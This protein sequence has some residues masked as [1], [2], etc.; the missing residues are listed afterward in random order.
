M[1]WIANNGSLIVWIVAGLG[2]LF[3]FDIPQNIYYHF[4]PSSK[5]VQHTEIELVDVEEDKHEMSDIS[6][7]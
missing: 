2:A 3:L 1:E 4:K 6:E 5:P 7:Q